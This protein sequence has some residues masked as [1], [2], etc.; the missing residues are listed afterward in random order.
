[1]HR[2]K[3]IIAGFAV[4]ILLLA[5][6]GET[7]TLQIGG[8]GFVVNYRLGTITYGFIVGA[9]GG[10][11]PS[12][13]KIVATLENPAGGEPFRF[14]QATAAARKRYDFIT[15][16]L[17]GVMKDK[18]YAVSVSLVSATGVVL[19]TTGKSYTIEVDPAIVSGGPLTTG[20]G[21]RKVA[22]K[23]SN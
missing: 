9:K 16:D 5:C 17:T 21:Y 14:E 4:A 1:M 19:S 15:P 6:S 12:G 8:G 7:T 13:S 23:P 3:A 10:A 18:A 2:M 22:P 20:P 11:L